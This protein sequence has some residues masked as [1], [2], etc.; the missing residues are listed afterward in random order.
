MLYFYDYCAL[1]MSSECHFSLF[2]ASS[3]SE[4]CLLVQHGGF[5]PLNG[6]CQEAGESSG[7]GSMLFSTSNV[8]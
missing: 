7:G 4:T 5:Y 8:Q 6:S 1:S 3:L 2:L